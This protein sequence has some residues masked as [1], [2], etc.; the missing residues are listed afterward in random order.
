M[1]SINSYILKKKRLSN[2]NILISNEPSIYSICVYNYFYSIVHTV[3]IYQTI[4]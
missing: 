2:I 4:N 3:L 1:T